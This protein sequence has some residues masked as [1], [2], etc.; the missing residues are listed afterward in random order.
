MKTV[1][2]N[3]KEELDLVESTVGPV[4]LSDDVLKSVTGGCGTPTTVAYSCVPRG[5][6]CP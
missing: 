2:L 3:Q 1:D 5:S 4:E 6:Y